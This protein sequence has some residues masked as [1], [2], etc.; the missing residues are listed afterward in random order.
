MF[1]RAGFFQCVVDDV[2]QLVEGELP[3]TADAEFGQDDS[4]CGSDVGHGRDRPANRF[5]VE[6]R[7]GYL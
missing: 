3:V 1:G 4:V 7:I 6:R 5:A 2:G